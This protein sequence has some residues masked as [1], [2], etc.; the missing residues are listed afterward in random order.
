MVGRRAVGQWRDT[1]WCAAVSTVKST[2]SRYVS[3]WLRGALLAAWLCL[4]CGTIRG[5]AIWTNLYN[6]SANGRD[7]AMAIT[8]GSDGTV[9][10]AGSSDGTGASG[11]YAIV[12]YTSAGSPI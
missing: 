8:V 7:I 10:V 6:G 2:P 12:A 5:Q 11:D 9:Y 4:S 3:V 1:C